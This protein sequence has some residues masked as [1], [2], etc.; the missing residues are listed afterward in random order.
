M[1][2]RGC[3]L[4]R[5]FSTTGVVRARIRWTMN[6]AFGKYLL[7]T[8]TVSSGVLML[9]G[10]LTEQELHHDIEQDDS[11]R[12]DFARLARMFTVGLAMGPVHHYY[13]GYVNKLWPRRNLNNVLKKVLADQLVMGPICILQFFYTI[14]GLEMRP[15]KDINQEVKAK[16]FTVYAM[17]WCIWPP[18]Q[19]INFFYVPPRYQVM[20]VNFVTMLYDVF[21]SFV[22][23]DF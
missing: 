10:D 14:G 1:L 18:T 15:L 2:Q 13:Y 20:Y 8:N 17:D 22:K 7:A 4:L 9:L 16:F 5:K 12:Y 6:A 21:L 23:H 11:P 3:R 19:F